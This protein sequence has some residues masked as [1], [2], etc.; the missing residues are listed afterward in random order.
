MSLR[1][2]KST[3]KTKPNYITAV[4]SITLVLLTIGILGVAL[5]VSKNLPNS[6]KENLSF[7]LELKE[8]INSDKVKKY[9]TALEK[10]SFCKSVVF[11]SKEEAG[12]LMQE[13]MGENFEELLGYN[14]L[15]SSF[16]IKLKA[17]YLENEELEAV[18]KQ[19]M[20]LG[21]VKGI[22][23]DKNLIN[24]INNY[25]SKIL[26]PLAV[27]ALL[28]FLIALFLIDSTIR[29]SM[30]S[31]RFVV[32]SMK[33][34]GATEWF[35]SKPFLKSGLII[36]LVSGVLA[37]LILIFSLAPMLQHWLNMSIANNWVNYLIIALGLVFLGVFIS[38][39]ST[40]RAVNKY[41]KLK[42]NDLY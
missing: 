23:Y 22:H 2:E 27:L 10:E 13:K 16:N 19:I 30:Y 7:Q 25:S 12:K 8:D 3:R 5:L 28:L 18:K 42:L 31:K 39:F 6:V 17:K 40:K 26:L 41:L 34:V 36:G 29:L 35:I 14:P 11:V 9:Q 1:K 32:R 37:S 38:V 33:L 15:Y 4:I 24:V 21:Y 20:Q